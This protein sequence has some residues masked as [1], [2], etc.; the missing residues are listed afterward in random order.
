MLVLGE[1]KEKIMEDV[2][3]DRKNLS[4]SYPA[5]M[6]SPRERLTWVVMTGGD[7]SSTR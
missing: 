6:V 5:A 3:A 2:L 4:K 1:G 7:L